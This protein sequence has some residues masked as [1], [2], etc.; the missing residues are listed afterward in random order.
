MN[1]LGEQLLASAAFA[2]DQGG[3]VTATGN[4]PQVQRVLDRPR[5]A[6]D[7]VEG[8]AGL[9]A[10]NASGDFADAAVFAH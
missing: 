10:D 1:G 5:G 6:L 8:I 3:G 7:G 9:G 2:E 4:A